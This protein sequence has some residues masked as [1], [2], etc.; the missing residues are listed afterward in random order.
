MYTTPFWS[1]N[2]GNFA[3]TAAICIMPI[4]LGAG[5]AV[6]YSMAYRF[7]SRLQAAIDAATLAGSIDLAKNTDGQVRRIVRDHLAANL[8]PVDF[9]QILGSAAI[10]IDRKTMKLT[11]KANA[12][13]PTAFGGIVNIPKINYGGMASAQAAWGGIEAVLVMD[14]TGSMADANKMIQLKATAKVFVEDLMALNEVETRVKVGVVPFAE[15][16]N[17]GVSNRGASWLSVPVF[18]I[19]DPWNGCVGSRSGTLSLQDQSYGTRVPAA[20]GVTCPAEITPLTAD[21]NRLLSEIDQMQTSGA[22]YIPAGISWGSRVL[23]SQAPFTG[24]STPAVQKR[25]NITKSLILMTDG[26]NTISKDPFS[27]YHTGRDLVETN[28]WTLEA[29]NEVKKQGIKVFT[30]TFGT[31]VPPATKDLIRACASGPENYFNAEDGIGLKEAFEQIA[32]SL[33][34][35]YLTQ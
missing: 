2:R 28:A 19:P 24:A 22:T 29:C 25:D 15:Y 11:V 20:L 9:K 17:V 35:L 14:N 32:D 1:D 10:T 7:D 6:D 34:R 16:V 27:H 12:S 4:V 31:A 23:S 26:A 21:K 5:I 30:L 18:S 3:V 8:E 33:K 13:M